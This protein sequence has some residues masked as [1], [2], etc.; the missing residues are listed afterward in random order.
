[1]LVSAL[2]TGVT[3]PPTGASTPPPPELDVVVII[4]VLILEVKVVG[5]VV[6]TGDEVELEP[7]LEPVDEPSDTVVVIVVREPDTVVVEMLT[8]PETVVVETLT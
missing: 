7:G 2:A 5:G 3:A 6:G 1:M 8:E 4:V